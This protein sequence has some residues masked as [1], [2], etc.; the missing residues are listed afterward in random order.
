MAFEAVHALGTA[1]TAASL[2][3]LGA[4]ARDSASPVVRTAAGWAASEIAR[5]EA[6]AGSRPETRREAPFAPGFRRGVSWWM[7]EGRQDHGAA[8]FRRLA[9]L[10]VTWVSLHTWEDRKSVV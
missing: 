3:A 1:G 2:G 5:R 8:S 6:G 7:S 10:G 4:A 9:S